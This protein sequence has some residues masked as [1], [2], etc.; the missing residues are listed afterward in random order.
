MTLSKQKTDWVL[1]LYGITFMSMLVFLITYNSWINYIRYAYVL[2]MICLT[3]VNGFRYTNKSVYIVFG[4][5]AVHTILFGF[6]F[7]SDSVQAAIN[8]NGKEILVFLLFVLTTAQYV[9]ENKRQEEFVKISQICISLFINYCYIT[10]FNGIAPIKFLPYLLTGSSTRVRFTFGLGATNR[11]AYMAVAVL[12]LSDMVLRN[13]G[14]YKLK[15]KMPFY[16]LYVL[17]SMAVSVLVLLSTQTRGAIIAV[18]AYFIICNVSFFKRKLKNGSRF[19]RICLR[20]LLPVGF[21]GY[22]YY[23]FTIAVNRSSFLMDNWNVFLQNA[24]RWLGLGY[25]SFS[26]FLTDV[27]NYGT[28]PMDCYYLYIICTTG[29]IGAVLIFGAL[30]YLFIK[31]SNILYRKVI[32]ELD[33]KFIMLFFILLFVSFSESLLIAPF[34]PYSYVFWIGFFLVLMNQKSQIK[35]PSASSTYLITQSE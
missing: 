24:N 10:N 19:L 5:L 12:I 3:I 4:I 8:D 28:S 34:V 15:G 13:Y 32:S 26:G 14:G 33:K 20:I 27:F 7:A 25:V 31:F 35:A 1:L 22:A 21:C 9:Y 23:V 18:L 30:I 6:I 2:I 11:A 29:I 17:V 16:K